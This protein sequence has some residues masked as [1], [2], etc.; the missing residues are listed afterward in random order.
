MRL[1]SHGVLLHPLTSACGILG[2]RDMSDLSPRSGAERTLIGS[3]SAHL[4]KDLGRGD[5]RKSERGHFPSRGG[6]RLLLRDYDRACDR[7]VAG[8][9][10][11]DHHGSGT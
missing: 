7:N 6:G 11:F 4:C 5:P 1:G 9:T 3:R 2:P 10:D 8:S